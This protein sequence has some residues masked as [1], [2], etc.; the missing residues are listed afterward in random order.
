MVILS[1][2]ALFCLL[3]NMLGA[4]FCVCLGTMGD[5]DLSVLTHLNSKI[6]SSGCGDGSK[7]FPC[8]NKK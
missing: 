6:F 5:L 1:L 2:A 3:L 4:S 7:L 8:S